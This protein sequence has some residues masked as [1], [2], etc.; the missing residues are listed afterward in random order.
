M[1][2]SPN[3]N[4]YMETGDRDKAFEMETYQIYSRNRT[5]H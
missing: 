5:F 4:E 3:D 2:N 1:N